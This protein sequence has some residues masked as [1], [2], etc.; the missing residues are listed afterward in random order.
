MQIYVQIYEARMMDT[1]KIQFILCG[2]FECYIVI[3]R[4]EPCV[5]TSE[6]F[7]FISASALSH[8]N[9]NYLFIL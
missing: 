6:R 3:I 5:V 7:P 2:L 1:S 4:D 8:N 9:H